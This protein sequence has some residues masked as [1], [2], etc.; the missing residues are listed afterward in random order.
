MSDSLTI[1]E[2]EYL[3]S[4]DDTIFSQGFYSSL[5]KAKAS[6]PDAVWVSQPPQEDWFASVDDDDDD[7]LGSFT[8]FYINERVVH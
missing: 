7:E 1:W 2:V 6:V 5:G 4:D 8:H 3:G